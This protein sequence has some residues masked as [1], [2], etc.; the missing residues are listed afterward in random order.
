M[1]IHPVQKKRNITLQYDIKQALSLAGA[2]SSRHKKLWRLPHIFAKVL[3]LPFNSETD[4]SIEETPDFIKFMV[5]TDVV[6]EDVRAH[7]VEIY[8]GVCKIVIREGDDVNEPSL[9]ELELGI[10]R[11]RLPGC[12]RLDLATATYSDGELVVL[13]PKDIVE[14]LQGE[15]D[16]GGEGG[17]G[18]QLFTVQ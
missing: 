6:G 5:F 9:E 4:V 15:E 17:R 14:G 13:V 18:E 2:L 3:E 12:T 8:P 7:T 10:W 16:D 1:K 11:F